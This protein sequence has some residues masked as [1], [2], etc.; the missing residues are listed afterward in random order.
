MNRID[1]LEV[2]RLVDCGATFGEAR[3]I[4][5]ASP[6]G[7]IPLRQRVNGKLTTQIY[8]PHAPS[9]LAAYLLAVETKNRK[10]ELAIARAHRRRACAHDW[11]VVSHEE[12]RCARCGTTEFVYD[13]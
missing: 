1:E 3:D 10:R 5:H 13:E 9:G 7:M 4:V 12:R 8:A 11:R 6:S 2:N